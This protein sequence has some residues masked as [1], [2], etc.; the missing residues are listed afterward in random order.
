[1]IE[2]G[3]AGCSPNWAKLA[4]KYL[5]LMCLA[6]M[7]KDKWFDVRDTKIIGHRFIFFCIQTYWSR[8]IKLNI[9][10]PFKQRHAQQCQNHLLPRWNMQHIWNNEQ[11]YLK[12][13]NIVSFS[14]F[15]TN[16]SQWK[17]KTWTEVYFVC[18]GFLCQFQHFCPSSAIDSPDN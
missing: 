8:Y 18:L 7:V 6:S 5:Y 15:V 13:K 4:G 10:F 14:D 12:P 17:R 16:H 2:T 1:M 11:K 9:S 3:I